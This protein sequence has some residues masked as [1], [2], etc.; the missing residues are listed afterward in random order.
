MGSPSESALK[1]AGIRTQPVLVPLSQSV[2]VGKHNLIADTGL[3]MGRSFRVGWGPAWTLVY[4]SRGVNIAPVPTNE[5]FGRE[6]VRISPLVSSKRSVSHRQSSSLTVNCAR[7]N[8]TPTMRW[9]S[10]VSQVKCIMI[11]LANS[12]SL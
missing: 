5:R 4:S 6:E 8:A 11:M 12:L 3:T 1:A 7:V 9:D 10:D 2:T